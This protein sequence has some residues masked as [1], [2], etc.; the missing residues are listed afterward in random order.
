MDQNIHQT[1][2]LICLIVSNE[3]AYTSRSPLHFL[4]RLLRL[5]ELI[6]CGSK[7]TTLVDVF[8]ETLGF[9]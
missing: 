1:C 9:S 4:D 3:H 6:G 2:I 7:L 8:D 5:V